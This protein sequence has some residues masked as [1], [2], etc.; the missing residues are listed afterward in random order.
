MPA[1]RHFHPGTLRAAE[2]GSALTCLVLVGGPEWVLA[3]VESGALLRPLASEAARGAP[4]GMGRSLE[5]VS[6]VLDPPGEPLDASRPEAVRLAD[7]GVTKLPLPRRRAVRRLLS[8]LVTASPSGPLLGSLG[9]SIAYQDLDGDRPSVVVVAPDQRP[10]FG[11]GRHGPWC[12]FSLA[13]R[14]HA[15]PLHGRPEQAL[16]LLDDLSGT[17]EGGPRRHR[18]RG[19]GA[20]TPRLLVV[21][22]G[23][24]RRGQVPKVVLG[25]V[26]ERPRR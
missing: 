19:P 17:A 5:L 21:G 24:P 14:K 2:A 9:P 23:P 6:V 13:G 1:A 10:R 18:R 8:V 25:A 3:D 7:G 4:A 12:Q 22:F 15:L 16:D 20:A 26:S 11:N